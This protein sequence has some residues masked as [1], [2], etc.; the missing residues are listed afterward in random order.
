MKRMEEKRIP[1]NIDW[2]AIDLL[3]LKLVKNLRK[4]ILRPLKRVVFQGV[5]PAD[6][7]ILMVYLERAIIRP[8]EKSRLTVVTRLKA[9]N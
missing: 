7:S 9:F 6:I 1:Q 8:A 2:D 5:N 3:L 4:S